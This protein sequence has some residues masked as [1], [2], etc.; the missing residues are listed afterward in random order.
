MKTSRIFVGFLNAPVL[1]VFW[2]TMH[3]VDSDQLSAPGEVRAVNGGSVTVSCQYDH[4]FRDNTKY[5]CK[6]FVYELCVIIV[7][8][9]RNRI[10][11]RFSI[12]DDKEAGI[13]NVTMTSLRQSDQD[14]YWCVI[15]RLGRNVYS[16]VKLVISKAVITPIN[17]TPTNSSVTLEQAEIRWWAILRWIIF[18]L[19]LCCLVST[20][21]TV[22]RMKAA[23]K[24]QL[25]QQLHSQNIYE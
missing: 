13:F 3:T 10:N 20:Y 15:S 21:I 17:I 11:D 8:T 24:T 23:Q 16:R 14:V 12:A 2:L 9:P 25:H 7:K 18:I 4:Q 22:W 5:W 6:G 1:F 19:M